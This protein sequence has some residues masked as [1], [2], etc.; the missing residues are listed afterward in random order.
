M[1]R[2]SRAGRTQRG[3][4]LFLILLAVVLFAA[5]SYAVTQSMRGGGKDGGSESADLAAA[6]ILQWFAAVD[7]AVMRMHVV[8]GIAYE[9]MSF[10]YNSLSSSGGAL[11]GY[12]HST[13]CTSNRCRVFLPEGGGVPPP[14]F[15]EHGA[16]GTALNG[17]VAEGYMYQLT[18]MP[19][20]GAGTD[21]N[22]IV[23]PFN[24]MKAEICDAINKRIGIS[25]RPTSGIIVNV[26]GKTPSAWDNPATSFLTPDLTQLMGKDTIGTAFSGSGASARCFIYHV[27]IK[28]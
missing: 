27:V 18:T 23:M 15:T 10:A 4:I 21:L 7:T 24:F 3:N 8:G 6:E 17:F 9:D 26:N 19:W 16:Q 13:R 1:H 25:E 20:P 12:S 2:T 22:D 5:L 11:S 14:I 28:R